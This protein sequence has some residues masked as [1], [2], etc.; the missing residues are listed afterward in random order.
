MTQLFY[1]ISIPF[2]WLMKGCLAISGQNYLIALIFF[3]LIIQVLL[4][5][6][7]GIKQQKNMRN[8]AMM[9]PKAAAIRK[10]YAGRDDQA[11]RQKMQQETME[12]YQ[13]H[14]YSPMGGCLPMLIQ[15]PIIMALYNV[16]V[17]PLQY[18]YMIS[19]QE[20]QQIVDSF[21]ALEP[22]LLS[23]SVLGELSKIKDGA[24]NI[25]YTRSAQMEILNLLKSGNAE[26]TKIVGDVV[27]D[28]ISYDIPDY[29]AFG[30]DF[31]TILGM[32]SSGNWKGINL[33][34]I[35]VPVLIVAVMI[36]SQILT[37]KFS[38]QDPTM[39]DQQNSCSMKAMMYTMPVFSA[40][41]SLSLPAAVGVYWIYRSVA[42][43][44]QQMIMSKIMPMP[45][46]T[47]EDYKAAEKELA[48]SSKKKKNNKSTTPYTGEKK[49]SLHHIDDDDDDY[50]TPAERAKLKAE[51]ED[52]AESDA[53][54]DEGP[55][56]N[57]EDAPV[58][59]DDKNTHYKKK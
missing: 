55:K 51:E 3:T 26:A 15:L 12:L 42:A 10:K 7:F 17:Y 50:P 44:L 45:K 13:E 39:Q 52:K 58:I 4:C 32:P 41:I 16:I 25:G 31:S 54:E 18:T 53:A 11:T 29:N 47:E 23:E 20:V 14:G 19:L 34:L 30:L 2:G 57:P 40:Y 6:I 1:Y 22:A 37:R 24:F 21:K 28:R 56:G 27:G 48:G 8:Q 9:A 59:K 43:T 46:F 35:L 5:L 36:F 49:R 38:Y 33:W